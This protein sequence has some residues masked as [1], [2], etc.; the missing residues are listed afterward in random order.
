MLRGLLNYLS[1]RYQLQRIERNQE[2][3]MATLA[4]LESAIAAAPANITSA[5]V[6][7]VQPIIAANAPDT[8]PAIDAVNALPAQVAAQV[9][10]ALTQT[11]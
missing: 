10:A 11:P 4:D 8:Q 5:V 1:L 9:A 7:A 3:I 6:T 2:L